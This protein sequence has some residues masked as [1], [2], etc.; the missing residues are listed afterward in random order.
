MSV[1]GYLAVTSDTYTQ[2]A[3]LVVFAIV[4]VI[5]YNLINGG[6]SSYIDP[7]RNIPSNITDIESMTIFT[8]TLLF[9]KGHIFVVVNAST[10]S[11]DNTVNQWWK[12][13]TPNLFTVININRLNNDP[14]LVQQF[15]KTYNISGNGN[16]ILVAYFSNGKYNQACGM[17]AFDG[18]TTKSFIFKSTRIRL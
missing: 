1:T 17:P 13:K 10:Q 7:D 9:N 2:L 16:K 8:K 18:S 14:V 15:N 4:L 12:K 11:L 6:L 3:I 5:V